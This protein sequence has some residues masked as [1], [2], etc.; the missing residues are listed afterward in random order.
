[1]CTCLGFMHVTL[2]TNQS[3]KGAPAVAFNQSF[4][5]FHSIK[6]KKKEHL[7]TDFGCLSLWQQL[8]LLNIWIG[9]SKML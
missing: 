6:K 9:P 1:M 3:H 7:D 5:T 2:E 8:K 4:V